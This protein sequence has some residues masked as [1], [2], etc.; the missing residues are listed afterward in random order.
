MRVLLLSLLFA[1]SAFGRTAYDVYRMPS[2]GNIPGWG[3]IARQALPSIGQQ[4][5]SS[6]GNSACNGSASFVDVTN[7]SV[8][9]TTTGRPVFV[10]LISDGGGTQAFFGATR[11]NTASALALFT[12]LRG[13]TEISRVAVNIAGADSSPNPLTT[14][15]PVGALFHIDVVGAGTYTY[16]VQ[17]N[18]TTGT[19]CVNQAK[20][21]AYE[22]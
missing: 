21:I 5:S 16:K 1:T 22:L 2:S 3:T 19:A 11:S 15:I 17:Q 12:I 4:I 14:Y 9:I 18:G 8:S 13:A 10:G 6:C 7:L 20:L